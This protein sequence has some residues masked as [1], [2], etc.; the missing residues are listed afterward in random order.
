[1]NCACGN[2]GST[3]CETC[4]GSVC[5]LC[6]RRDE[7][8][9]ELCLACRAG[10]IELAEDRARAASSSGRF[11][12]AATGSGL[13]RPTRVQRHFVYVPLVVTVLLAGVA[14]VVVPLFADARGAR[15]ERRAEAA[16]QAIFE[17][18][19]AGSSGGTRDYLTLEE[20]QQR[21]LVGIQDVPGY[22][23][24]VELARDRKKF[25]ARAIPIEAGLR[26]F[27]VDA[28]GE[29]QPEGE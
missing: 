20:L 11:R 2:P 27:Y 7:K 28:L 29:V 17:A 5:R 19:T 16:L 14:A 12:V 22:E 1:M 24:R 4:R 10:A 23:V 3:L 6:V 13:H 18:Q 9:A 15:A 25:W 26:R 8:G 21:R